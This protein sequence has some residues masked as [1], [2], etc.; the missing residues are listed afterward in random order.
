MAKVVIPRSSE[1]ICELAEAILAKDSVLADASPLKVLNWTEDAAKVESV[2][3]KGREAAELNRRAEEI[4]E[5]RQRELEALMPKI[6]RSRDLLKGYYGKDLRK[7]G[8]FGFEV[9]Y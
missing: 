4:N 8:E 9:N 7:L 3:S 6:R 5:E 1:K 2:R